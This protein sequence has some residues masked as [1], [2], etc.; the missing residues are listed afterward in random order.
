MDDVVALPLQFG[1]DRHRVFANLVSERWFTASSE[2][3]DQ[4]AAEIVDAYRQGITDPIALSEH[5]WT[6]A[7]L[8]M[9]MAGWHSEH[10]F[11]CCRN[12][13]RLHGGVP[14]VTSG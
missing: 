5:C 10:P 12:E 14:C 4:F 13:D 1:G 6:M 9:E 8:T 3:R 11:P 7:N 2:R